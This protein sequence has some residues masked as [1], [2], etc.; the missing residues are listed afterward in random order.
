MATEER[1]ILVDEDDRE[2]GTEE[3]LEAHKQG[4]LHRAFSIF[5]VDSGRRM[6]IQ[7]RASGKYHSAGLWSNTCCG[8]P[9]PGEPVEQA[10]HK[11]LREEMGFDCALEHAFN[12]T[13]KAYLGNGLSEN[14]YDRVFVGQF[15]G[16][17]RPNPEEVE[18]WRWIAMEEL[19]ADVQERPDR[20]TYWLGRCLDGVIQRLVQG[21]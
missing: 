2:I 19:R 15:E 21:P 18:D 13:Y 16:E 10:A 14:E 8:H 20:Y 12:F 6:L 11:R 17:P 9:L 3:K 7:K 1:V 5:V 4:L